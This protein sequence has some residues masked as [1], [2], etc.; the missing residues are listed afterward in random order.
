M[1]SLVEWIE[2]ATSEPV[3][4]VVIGEMGWGDYGSENVP[5]YNKQ[6]RGRILSWEE[7]KPWL[8]Y[9]FNSGYGAPGCNSIY[10]W[11]ENWVL[12]VSQYDGATQLERIPRNPTNCMPEMPGG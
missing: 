2:E 9:E 10:A 5:N 6:P 12:F 4:A 11:T 7:A 3:L 8:S 1:S